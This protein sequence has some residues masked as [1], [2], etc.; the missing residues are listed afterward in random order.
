MCT[1]HSLAANI[2]GEELWAVLFLEVVV[3]SVAGDGKCYKV[4]PMNLNKVVNL[5]QRLDILKVC[6]LYFSL[7]LGYPKVID[8]SLTSLYKQITNI[9]T[10]LPTLILTRCILESQRELLHSMLILSDIC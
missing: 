6:H 1:A 3:Y 7:L 2:V 9:A 10:G 8:L 5:E 4:C